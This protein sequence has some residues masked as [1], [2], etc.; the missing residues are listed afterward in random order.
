MEQQKNKNDK[1]NIHLI[2]NAHLD[3]VWLWRWQEGCSE[4]LSTFR[5]AAELTEEFPGF[6]FNHNEAILY[7]WAK[8]NDSRLYENIKAKV[9]EGK[10]HIMGGWY[11]QP[12][13]N[14]PSGESI[15]RNIE[16]GR[17]FFKKEFDKVP[18]T[19]INFDSF[20]HSRGLVQILAKA[21]Y[22]SYIICRPAKDWYDFD[23]QDFIW[24]GF[25]GA[26]VLVHRSDENYNSVWGQAAEELKNFLAD[27]Q[28]EEVTMFL[29]GVGD[30]GGGPSRKDLSD[31][32]K[33]IENTEDYNI[34]HSTP[35]AYFAERKQLP[36]E[37]KRVSEGLNP[38]APGC[39]TSQIRVKQKHRLLENE[40]YS[41]EKM[42]AAAELL[43]GRH[44]PRD[45]FH[46]TVKALLFSEFHDALPGSGSSYVEEDTLRLL[47]HGLELVSREKHLAALA[48]ASTQPRVKEG[49]ST[50]LF[51]N[52]HPYDIT[53]VFACEVGLPKQN[54]TTEF[55]YPAAEMNGIRI[56]TQAEKECSN[57]NLDWRKKVV[58][59]ATLKA[60]AMNRMD[61]FFHP[62]EKRPVYQEI[63]S[64]PEFIFDNGRM[65]VIIDTTTGL[66]KEYSVDK[67]VYLAK[68]S[69][70]LAA[71]DDTYNSW[72]IHAEESHVRR[73][74]RLLLPQE[75]SDFC[76]LT[77]RVIAPVRIIEDGAVRTTVEAVFGMH[78]SKAYLRYQLPKTG[79]DFEVEL[80]VFN[81]EKNQFLKLMLLT[82]STEND[83]TG[84]IMF[85][86]EP[87]K[88]GEET[89]SQKWVMLHEKASGGTLAVLNKGT[90]GASYAEGELGIT[91]LRSAG[92][93]ASDSVMGKALREE[94]WA[95][96][97]E[98]GE[99]YY[100]FKITAGREEELGKYL[101]RMA[102]AYNEEPYGFAYCPPGYGNEEIPHN[103]NGFI[104]ID[105]PRVIL[106]AMKQSEDR[107]GYILRLYESMGTDTTA[108]ISLLNNRIQE[109]ITFKAFEIKTYFLSVAEEKLT[110]TTLI[111]L[112]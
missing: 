63:Q 44:Y 93:A 60:G 80:G 14:M 68:G 42:A 31:L 62:V 103:E 26:S 71:Y 69:F 2:A 110:E 21:G 75:G 17:R 89:V 28:E 37:L 12:D 50:I 111:E 13:C 81:Q 73:D 77:D 11:L 53:G 29:W 27:K 47:D 5:T 16:V 56:P 1:K 39:Y 54:W 106:S 46:E 49:S 87:L 58:V 55:M 4:A 88:H 70:Q 57:F 15:I 24:E 99:R 7:K 82:P 67:K 9:R 107:N 78:N 19:A 43:F 109:K 112:D 61:V 108:T 25:A 84:Q 3:P 23:E 79:T 92:Y 10:W 22:T 102:Q 35:E 33:Y 76:G 91:L 101:D 94:Q 32:T 104:R 105:N 86:R 41:A 51:Y 74:F 48:L 96:R 6:L 52:P 30:H 40:L 8:E 98:Q 97:M 83:F 66:L 45:V 95:P 64:K 38:V 36:G 90:Y 85:G 72:G 34:L 18:Q 59:Q 100:Q 65:R 20:G